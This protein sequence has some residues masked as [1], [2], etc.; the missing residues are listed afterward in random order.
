MIA[1]KAL[2]EEGWGGG[3]IE[4]CTTINALDINV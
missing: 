2:K 1:F 4:K 3:E